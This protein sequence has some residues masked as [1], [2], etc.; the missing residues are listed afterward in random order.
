MLE[1]GAKL[2]A[3]AATGRNATSSRTHA[4]IRIT[5]RLPKVPGS[6]AMQRAKRVRRRMV[7]GYRGGERPEPDFF[8]RHVTLVD[9][10]GS[11]R[12]RDSSTHTA[13]RRKECTE[14]NKSLMC[15]KECIRFRAMGTYVHRCRGAAAIEGV[16]WLTVS[17]ESNMCR[18]VPVAS[19]CF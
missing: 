5:V 13:E 3:T 9:L 7:L 19:H 11:E 1:A 10:A 6:E 16:T 15:L 12:N 4:I 8:E 17:A 14:I 2:R 18:T